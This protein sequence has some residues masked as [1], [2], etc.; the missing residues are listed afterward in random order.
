LL[1][2]IILFFLFILLTQA[3]IAVTPLDCKNIA[4]TVDKFCYDSTNQKIRINL[5]NTGIQSFDDITV[6]FTFVGGVPNEDTYHTNNSYYE[7]MYQKVH[8]G[9]FFYR[10]IESCRGGTCP[11]FKDAFL[12]SISLI[13]SYVEDLPP[14]ENAAEIG[15]YETSR[16]IDCP[17]QGVKLYSVNDCD[18]NAVAW[19][20]SGLPIIKDTENTLVIRQ[21]GPT[22]FWNAFDFDSGQFTDSENFQ[23]DMHWIYSQSAP[24]SAPQIVAGYGLS[25]DCKN[26]GDEKYQFFGKPQFC[27]LTDTNHIIQLTLLRTRDNDRAYSYEDLGLLSGNIPVETASTPNASS[28]SVNNKSPVSK[29]GSTTSAGTELSPSK[30]QEVSK[31]PVA[32]GKSAFSID[33][34]KSYIFAFLLFLAIAAIA[35]FLYKAGKPSGE[36]SEEE[37]PEKV[38]EKR[39]EFNANAKEAISIS[40]F[41]VKYRNALVLDNISFD[42]KRANIAC[43]LGPSGTGKSTVLEALVGRKKPDKGDMKILGEDICS[44]KKIY[45]TVGFVPQSPEVYMNQTVE[46]NI[47]SS[48]AKWGISVNRSKIDEILSLV[49][50]NDRRNVKANRLSGG[51]LKLLSLGMELIRSVEVLILDEP[52]TGLDPNTRNNIITILS[53]LST[54][55]QKTVLFTT[56]FM[57]DAEECDEVIIINK[58]KIVAQGTP[59]QMKRRLPGNGKVVNILLDNVTDDLIKKIEGIKDVEKVLCEGRSLRII[60]GAPNAIKLGQTIDDLGGTVNKTEVLGASMMDVFVYHTGHKPEE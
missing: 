50:L 14:P 32:K 21:N 26:W 57:D 27:I 58:G 9:S 10:T 2:K 19:S 43:L 16:E 11:I 46:E 36:S 25:K 33:S 44:N 31:E 48:C 56:H 4:F 17:E 30:T 7:K 54:K 53:R 37:K 41:T 42:I 12:Y 60:T 24:S 18:S 5:L 40:N 13:P 52:T 59:E 47:S 6:Y 8:A 38:I 49:Q 39:P 29:S 28:L 55:L 15:F 3:V 45:E 51:Q 23:G 34:Y 35:L 1:K 22:A 20:I